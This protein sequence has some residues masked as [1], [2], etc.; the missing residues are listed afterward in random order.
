[1]LVRNP[2]VVAVI[3]IALAGCSINRSGLKIDRDMDGG[4][5]DGA[6]Y[7]GGVDPVVDA[8]YDACI[9]CECASD[10]DCS[11]PTEMVGDCVVPPGDV[12]INR[13]MR[14]RT[15]TTYNCVSNRCRPSPN[16][17]NESCTIPTDGIECGSRSEG[18][19]GECTRGEGCSTDGTQVRAVTAHV[20]GGGTC[21]MQTTN[22]TQN[23]TIP[24]AGT[25]CS[26]LG[27]CR[28]E[29]NGLSFCEPRGCSADAHCTGLC[30]GATPDCQSN[31]IGGNCCRCR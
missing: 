27:S 31:P 6:R 28:G 4:Q 24:T 22:E 20:C 21:A 9:D 8:G 26:G 13:G 12:C 14:P 25:V 3:G 11:G 2:V 7:D 1:V 29:C 5:L 16:T 18:P 10:A 15:T 23:C 17:I 19:W 30:P